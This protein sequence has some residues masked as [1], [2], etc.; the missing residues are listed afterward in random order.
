MTDKNKNYILYISLL[1][2]VVSGC[3]P[4]M[5]MQT[6]SAV[7]VFVALILAYFIRSREEEDHLVWHHATFVIRTIWIWSLFIVIGMVGAGFTVQMTAD[8]SAIDALTARIMEGMVPSEYD[9]EASTQ[10][11]LNTNY[12][13]ILT[14]TIAWLAPAQVY[15]LWRVYKGLS[16]AKDGYRVQ[17]LRGWF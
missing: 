15:A 7:V 10:A 9:I 5:T 1:I 14:T 13:L 4:H 12:N 6:V 2:G 8:M 3:M 17:N 16:R 11:Y